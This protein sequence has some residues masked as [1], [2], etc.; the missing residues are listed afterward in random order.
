M[1]KTKLTVQYSVKVLEGITGSVGDPVYPSEQTDQEVESALDFFTDNA[2]PIDSI[3]QTFSSVL[4]L[5]SV[6]TLNYL[7]DILIVRYKGNVSELK[8]FNEDRGEKMQNPE[9]VRAPQID[10]T[11]KIIISY[12][13]YQNREYEDVLSLLRYNYGMDENKVSGTFSLIFESIRSEFLPPS[14]TKSFV[15]DFKF[16]ENQNGSIVTGSVAR[17]TSVGGGYQ[18]GY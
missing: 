16:C 9:N 2:E 15:Y 14:T 10:E 18:G 7:N 17:T 5:E 3:K 13:N 12:E 4:V 11:K 1:A 8:G 6:N